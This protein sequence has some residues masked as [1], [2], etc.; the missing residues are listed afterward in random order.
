[1]QLEYV[2]QVKGHERNGQTCVICAYSAIPND[3][4]LTVMFED[5][6]TIE[7]K[8][9][10]IKNKATLLLRKS[11]KKKQLRIAHPKYDT[12]IKFHSF[13]YNKQ[14]L[15]RYLKE[16]NITMNDLFNTFISNL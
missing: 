10:Q 1:M 16:H 15:K 3:D 9:N 4:G 6:V 8:R 7:T 2:F 12:Q 11:Y 14:K 5:G 13:Q